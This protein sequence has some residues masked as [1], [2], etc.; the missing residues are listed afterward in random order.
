MP[1]LLRTFKINSESVTIFGRLCNVVFGSTKITSRSKAAVLIY[2]PSNNNVLQFLTRAAALSTPDNLLHWK[3]E[4]LR[5]DPGCSHACQSLTSPGFGDSPLRTVQSTNHGSK[6]LNLKIYLE[7][8]INFQCNPG[9]FHTK[10]KKYKEIEILPRVSGFFPK[11][12]SWSTQMCL[13]LS[14][15]QEGGGLTTLTRPPLHLLFCSILDYLYH[16][17]KKTNK[18]KRGKKKKTKSLR[19]EEW[20]RVLKR[21]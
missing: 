8:K 7:K 2:R 15:V 12:E 10:L 17:Y 3:L 9:T 19:P 21:V 6:Y 13:F 4:C 11:S 1:P 18:K 20:F 5:M 16:S 14:S